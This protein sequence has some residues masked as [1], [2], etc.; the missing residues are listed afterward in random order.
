MAVFLQRGFAILGLFL[1]LLIFG[2]VE[3]ENFGCPPG[4]HFGSN[5][6]NDNC[7]RV[8]SVPSPNKAR[9]IDDNYCTQLDK[10]A[11]PAVIKCEEENSFI[12][13]LPKYHYLIQKTGLGIGIYVPTNVG[14]SKSNFRNR[15]GSKIEY[16]KWGYVS[17]ILGGIREPGP[18]GGGEKTTLLLTY[19]RLFCI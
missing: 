18:G 17:Y 14:W 16:T 5:C 13:T 4:W 6:C 8:I 12:P 10:D 15:D 11:M 1:G 2:K 3:A 9:A 7:Y 19:K